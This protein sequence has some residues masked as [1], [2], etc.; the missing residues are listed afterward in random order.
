VEGGA[1]LNAASDLS[2]PHVCHHRKAFIGSPKK[3]RRH[4][5]SFN[6]FPPMTDPY[7]RQLLP[8]RRLNYFVRRFRIP[9]VRSPA[10]YHASSSRPRVPYNLWPSLPAPWAR[11]LPRQPTASHLLDRFQVIG[12]ICVGFP[13]TSLGGSY[14]EAF[15][16]PIW[17]WR[18][19]PGWG[20]ACFDLGPAAI[21]VV[22]LDSS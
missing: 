12:S 11:H 5:Y 16:C 17:I 13:F 14:W 10:P 8:K 20:L 2:N 4:A 7:L 19:R 22:S 9:W 15:R 18:R 1:T 6:P 21:P 3:L